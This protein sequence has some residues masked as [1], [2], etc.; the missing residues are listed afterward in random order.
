[1]FLAQSRAEE[2]GVVG[3][4]GGYRSVRGF[5]NGR[6]SKAKPG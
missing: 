2:S 6:L 3:T 1:L 5:C 4:V